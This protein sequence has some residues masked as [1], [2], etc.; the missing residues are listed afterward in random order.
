MLE[1]L[2]WTLRRAGDWRWF[3]GRRKAGR[4]VASTNGFS[5]SQKDLLDRFLRSVGPHL[6]ASA[7][8]LSFGGEYA[9]PFVRIRGLLIFN[10][11]YEVLKALIDSVLDNP[12]PNF[13]GF[14]I[15]G[16]TMVSTIDS[17]STFRQ[18]FDAYIRHIA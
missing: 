13:K 15:T 2:Q 7:V 11:E 9:D 8:D 1:R 5:E 17:G 14:D 6:P 4:L 10:D 3:F 18:R 16:N 12:P